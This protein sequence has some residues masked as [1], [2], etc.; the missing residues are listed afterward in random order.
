[1]ISVSFY[2]LLNYSDFRIHFQYMGIE[3][4]RKIW[5][6]LIF[7]DIFDSKSL[8][9]NLLLTYEKREKGFDFEIRF[10]SMG[11]EVMFKY[12]DEYFE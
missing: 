7:S 12:F 9:E 1:M 3:V 8:V 5:L 10:Y 11:I 2:F 4:V 6:F